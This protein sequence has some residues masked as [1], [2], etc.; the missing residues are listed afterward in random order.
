[1]GVVE[2][3][4]VQRISAAMFVEQSPWQMYAPDGSW[5]LGSYGLFS[6]SALA[7]LAARLQEN[8]RICHVNNVK[9][10]LNRI[11]ANHETDFFV[12]ESLKCSPLFLSKL[13]ADHANKDWRPVL[14]LVTCP[15][16]VLAGRRSKVFPFE[17]VQH[18][19][20][21]MPNARLIPF[22]EG[23]HWLYYEEADR[24]NS[25]VTAF[26]QKLHSPS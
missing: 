14:Q 6:E 17:G 7:N 2:L 16:L 21:K 24:F 23:S 18:A 4:G 9:T 25:V 19:A 22:D 26:L 10:C 20:D 12:T 1:M 11:P 13:M 3:F 15:A 8:P 5:L